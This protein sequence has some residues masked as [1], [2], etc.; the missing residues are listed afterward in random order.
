MRTIQKQFYIHFQGC[1]KF[2][3][4]LSSFEERKIYRGKKR[5]RGINI[6]FPIIL[7]LFGRISSGGKGKGKKIKIWKNGAGEEYQVVG[8]F[9]HPCTYLYQS[10]YLLFLVEGVCLLCV[11][12]EDVLLQRDELLK[13]PT[14]RGTRER[15]SRSIYLTQGVSIGNLIFRVDYGLFWPQKSTFLCLAVIFAIKHTIFLKE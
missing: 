1:I 8:N 6:N 11:E 14:T 15:S 13:L 9:I 3:S 7:G 12:V 4:P 2:L 5:V 10:I